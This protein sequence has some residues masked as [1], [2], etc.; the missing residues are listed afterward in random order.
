MVPEGWREGLMK[1]YH[2]G[3]FGGHLGRAKMVEG[4][5]GKFAWKGMNADI[6]KHV[7]TCREC[8]HRSA[9][10]LGKAPIQDNYQAEFPFQKVSIDLMTGLPVTDRGNSVLL[11]VVDCFTRWVEIIPLPS[12]SAKEVA[13]ALRD[14]VFFRHGVCDIVSDNGAELVS[15]ITKELYALMG[16]R[17]STCTTYHPQSQGKVER[18]HRVIADMLAKYIASGS[19]HWDM[20]VASCQFAMNNA[21]HSATKH[22]PYYLLHGRAPRLPTD[23]VM[24]LGDEVKWANY[25]EYVEQM[26]R[27]T[28]QAFDAVKE[29]SRQA[30]RANQVRRNESARLR[31]LNVGDAVLLHSPQ[32][33][34]GQSRKLASPWKSGYRVIDKFGQVNYYIEHEKTQKRQLVHI[35]RLKARRSHSPFCTAPLAPRPSRRRSVSPP[36]PRQ[37]QPDD[38][39]SDSPTG[40][41]LQN[42]NSPSASADEDWRD[43]EVGADDREADDRGTARCAPQEGGRTGSLTA[44]R[45][46]GG[47]ASAESQRGPHSRAWAAPHTAGTAPPRQ[48]R[49]RATCAAPPGERGES[50]RFGAERQREDMSDRSA[51]SGGATPEPI[52]SSASS[53][54]EGSLTSSSPEE[55]DAEAGST[56]SHHYERL[57]DARRYPARER[58][59]PDRYSP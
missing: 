10:F 24:G 37:P 8:E 43:A 59:P 32:T 28:R 50:E 34:P 56:P 26:L 54:G 47:E 52:S 33:K 45:S 49:P 39:L 15:Q 31:S 48:G 11:T 19:S 35:D 7:Q 30:R 40:P 38:R 51:G 1:D 14:R 25:H 44:D 55:S 22:T 41:G 2:Q 58:R 20:Y 12:R 42:N 9:G 29:S 4:I 6:K 53:D 46:R 23:A 21:V 5:Q 36:G 3:Q 57:T 18:T 13:R 16:A 27:A 17:A